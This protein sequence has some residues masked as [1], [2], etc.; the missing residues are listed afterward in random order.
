[1]K[2]IISKTGKVYTNLRGVHTNRKIIIFESDDWG[3][4]RMPDLNT[5]NRLLTKMPDL[6]KDRFSKYDSI[7]NVKDLELLFELL[8]KFKDIKGNNPII[9]A[10]T[11]VAN[12]DFDKIKENNFNKYEF[13]TFDKTISKLPEGSKILNLWEL[14]VKEKIFKPQLHGREHLNVPF[15]LDELR[16]GNKVLLNAFDERCFGVPFKS[17]IKSKR[18]NVMSAFDCLGLEGEVDFHVNSVI[19]ASQLFKKHFGYH[20]KSFIAPT[21]VWY[22]EIEKALKSENI[23]ILQGI[24][25][26]YIPNINKNIF[27]RK[28]HYIGQKNKFDQFYVTRNS[29]FEPTSNR[30]IDWVDLALSKIELAF[31]YRKPAIIGTHRINFI[32]SLV[33]KNRDENLK[34]FESLIKGILKK[35]PD[36]EFLSTD[37]LINILN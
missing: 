9:T 21:H 27:D 34:K 33:E 1:M 7:A 14:G 32:G 36:V 24:P 20:S 8:K 6:E 28:L 5:Y 26:Q 17:K 35:W 11:I 22:K 18:N 10:N 15:W 13:E 25:F 3:S 16:M 4:I 37:K 29:F 19:E 30:D 2:N 23:D 31:K 12:P